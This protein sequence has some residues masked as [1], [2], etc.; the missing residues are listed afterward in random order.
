MSFMLVGHTKFSPDWC[1]GLL[2][3]R[4]RRTF[5][6]SLQDV[7]DVVN[8]SA[9]V[10]VAQI[11]GT[12]DGSV[13]VPMYDWATYLGQ[14]FRKLAGMKSYHH[15]SAS[16]PGVTTVKEFSDSES[17]SFK[18]QA[19]NSWVPTADELPPLITPLGLSKERQWYLYNQIREFCRAGTED[20]VCPLPSRPL[21]G[22]DE[23]Q[24]EVESEEESE[25][26][27]PPAKRV[28]KC[29]LCGNPGHTRR[30]CDQREQ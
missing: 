7:A 24:H 6:S 12:Q 16:T 10:N 30:T 21:E 5:V 27:V 28:R 23:N 26:Q 13:V 1:F 29:G 14:H 20:L 25:A 19:D 17:S 3:Q 9:D 11:V 15:F 8:S 22:C 18:L 4:Y 2:K